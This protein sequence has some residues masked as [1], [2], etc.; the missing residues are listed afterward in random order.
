MK[1]LQPLLDRS[2][3]PLTQA[4]TEYSLRK[5]PLAALSRLVTGIST[6]PNSNAGTLVV[7]LPGSKKAVGECLEVLLGTPDRAGVLLH[8]L[9]LC[10]GKSSGQA[11]HRKLQGPSGHR[12]PAG[13]EDEQVSKGHHSDHQHH[14]HHHHHYS[15]AHGGLHAHSVPKARTT[16]QQ[17]EEAARKY[18]SQDAS[19][20]NAMVE[21]PRQSPYP[22]LPLEESLRLIAQ[23]SP[24]PSEHNSI[25]VDVSPALVGHVLAEDVVA[26]RNLPPTA[27][28]NVDGY[29]V[30]AQSTS[31]GEYTVVTTSALRR[32]GSPLQPGKE[33]CRVNTGQGLPEGT[34]AIIMV[35]DTQLTSVMSSGSKHEEAK[36][37]VLAQVD[38]GENVRPFA[39]DVKQG[40]TVLRAGTSFSPSG[41]EVGTLAFLGLNKVKVYRKPT[42]AVLSTGEELQD[43]AQRNAE[44]DTSS[45][46]WAHSSFDTNRPS[47]ITAL[48]ALGIP[49]V[50]LGIVGDNPPSALLDRIRQ[51]L[52]KA[53]VLVTTGA[54]SMGESD[55]LKSLI[56]RSLGE[57]AAIHF[58]RVSMKP[59]KPTTFAT[60]TDEGQ[61]PKV[62]FAL[63]GNPASALVCFYVFVL[64]ALRKMSGVPA[65]DKEEQSGSP[66]NPWSVPLLKG[67]ITLNHAMSLDKSRPEFH[68]VVLSPSPAGGFVAQST[69][70]SQRS[71]GMH[72]MSGANALVL[73]PT[74]QDAG[75]EKQLPKGAK[76]EG[77]LLSSIW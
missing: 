61:P 24:A 57:N 17:R 53:D 68:R 41:G 65:V 16:P 58:G 20:A 42:V 75:G 47:L 74:Q 14:H 38:V 63:P 1:A 5:T 46:D 43:I 40:T 44:R 67:C 33:V 22:I 51:G 4:L 23:H 18:L 49:T 66:V 8:A 50:D 36:I 59:G 52:S 10:S 60:V 31:E 69:T 32:R 56:E 39:S 55:N 30:P 27:T 3:G 64:P 9:E 76:V 7:A 54:T 45:S 28:T 71:S 34:D 6:H 11:T 21:R 25:F 2:T 72:S 15:H 12:E 73:L 29:A 26:P 19:G 70:Q 48:T 62:I 37:Q 77:M 13:S 35:E